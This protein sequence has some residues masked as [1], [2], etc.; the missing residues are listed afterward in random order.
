MTLI[1]DPVTRD[2]EWKASGRVCHFF[3]HPIPSANAFLDRTDNGVRIVGWM[4]G[5]TY[6]DD[7]RADLDKPEFSGLFMMRWLPLLKLPEFFRSEGMDDATARWV[8]F[9]KMGW[10]TILPW[11]CWK[12]AGDPSLPA[13]D[14]AYWWSLLNRL[15]D[16]V[17]NHGKTQRD[18]NVKARRHV[19]PA[20]MLRHPARISKGQYGSDWH[21]LSILHH[22]DLKDSDYF[23]NRTVVGVQ[24]AMKEDLTNLL[25]DMGEVPHAE[26]IL[27]IPPDTT[28]APFFANPVR[29]NCFNVITAIVQH[30]EEHLDVDN[31]LAH[32]NQLSRLFLAHGVE[33]EAAR[34]R[35]FEIAIAAW[36]VA[37]GNLSDEQIAELKLVHGGKGEVDLDH[38]RAWVQPFY[39]ESQAAFKEVKQGGQ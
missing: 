34:D 10:W 14:R 18:P 35:A 30:L 27:A 20:R 33:E 15:M 4:G 23:S 8:D 22:A 36:V 28:T 2:Q 31:F 9:H 5:I 24:K 32:V 16:F 12:H 25:F 3:K 21:Q 29:P 19:F 17:E 11:A 26:Q 39:E 13:L 6:L 38:A 37:A 7:V 1:H